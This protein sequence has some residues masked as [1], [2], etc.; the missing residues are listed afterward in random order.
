MLSSGSLAPDIGAAPEAREPLLFPL[1]ARPDA[2][3]LPVTI[4]AIE[5]AMRV[6]RE[7]LAPTPLVSNPML[8]ERT[9]CETLV[10][11]ENSQSI[12]SFKIRGALNLFANVADEV[13][14]RGVVTATRGNHGQAIA[15]AA[16]MHGVRCTVFVPRGNS[17]AKN[18]AIAMLG[19]HVIEA[20]H[21]FDAAMIA[22]EKF[23]ALN[24]A[25]L[26]HQGRD[27]AMIA[28][29]GTIALELLEQAGGPL[30]AVLVPVGAG[31]IAAGMAVAIK[32][33]SPAT[34]VIG[35]SAENAPAMHHAWHTGEYLPFAAIDTLADGLAVRV[36]VAVTLGIM[37]AL[38]DGL[39]L[40]S[41]REM[42]GAIRGYAET[43][44]Q[45]AEGA[46]AAALAAAI[47]YRAEFDGQRIAL[48]L[49]GGNI[50]PAMLMSALAG[51]LPQ[52]QSQAMPY[53]PIGELS[54]GY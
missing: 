22:A 50:D 4:E 9:G 28:G 36:P 51:D 19:A 38:L 10:K 48:V 2:S 35:V 52:H 42:Q 54:Y 37:R 46:A 14:T 49:T 26:V 12:G 30:D 23:A 16:R 21:D 40:V 25:H 18:A 27:P 33:L 6:V 11:L 8:N 44:H 43:I 24:G 1:P 13:R 7:Q 45:L 3:K 39:V 29:A 31:S 32:A 34:R 17:P 53:F 47:R 15:H 20:G 41:E 5:R